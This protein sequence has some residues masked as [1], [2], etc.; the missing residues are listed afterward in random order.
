M[1]TLK[2]TIGRLENVSP[3]LKGPSHIFEAYVAL[4]KATYSCPKGHLP[5]SATPWTEE[6]G[7]PRLCNL[8]RRATWLECRVV[9]YMAN[10]E[11]VAPSLPLLTTRMRGERPGQ[12]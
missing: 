8:A 10:E 3:T 4:S 5:S 12:P 9:G 6:A 11:A 1:S 7:L 2:F